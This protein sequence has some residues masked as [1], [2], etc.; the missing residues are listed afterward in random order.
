[1][2][3][4]RHGRNGAL[5]LNS[6]KDAEFINAVRARL[7]EGL[8]PEGVQRLRRRVMRDLCLSAI[9][10]LYLVV[11]L[12]AGYAQRSALR[13]AVKASAA[14]GF[15]AVVVVHSVRYRRLHEVPA[16][17]VDESQIVDVAKQSRR[18][19]RCGTIV[20]PQ[21]SGECP[22]CGHAP[23]AIVMA[24]VMGLLMLLAVSQALR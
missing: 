20:L 24:V 5:P 17:S 11:S 21:E 9:V 16:S 2:Q 12:I 18:C 6:E 1:M 8:R 22:S 3:R 14:L 23:Q 15:V 4:P 7:E 19:S 13:N 10:L